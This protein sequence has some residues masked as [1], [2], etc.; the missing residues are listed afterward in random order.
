MSE[1]E[2]DELRTVVL[3]VSTAAALSILGVLTAVTF[4]MV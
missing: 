4:S 1:Q 3:S 2:E